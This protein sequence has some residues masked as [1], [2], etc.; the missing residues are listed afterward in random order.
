MH[1]LERVHAL[2]FTQII[3]QFPGLLQI[4][5]GGKYILRIAPFF[6][7]PTMR[8]YLSRYVADKIAAVTAHMPAIKDRTT[9]ITVHVEA[10]VAHLTCTHSS[11]PR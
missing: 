8:R 6:K 10:V 9:A 2:N 7:Q 5:P 1:L 11:L 3:K 4:A